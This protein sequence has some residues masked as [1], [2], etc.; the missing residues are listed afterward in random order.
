M[1]GSKQISGRGET[2]PL[3]F[4]E[5]CSFSLRAVASRPGLASALFC[6]GLSA[7]GPISPEAAADQCEERARRAQG[8]TGEARIGVNSNEGVVGGL[9]IGITSDFIAGRDPEQV[10]LNCVRQLTGQE[11][12]RPVRL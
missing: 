8:P 10:Y 2:L 12:V 6:A 4:K 9:E 11:P 1:T 5:L 3:H 7:C